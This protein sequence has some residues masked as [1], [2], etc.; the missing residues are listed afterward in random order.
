LVT[1]DLYAAESADLILYMEDGRI[2]EQGAHSELIELDGRYAAMVALM[3]AERARE[4]SPVT[5]AG[6]P[7]GPAV[8][9]ISH[10]TE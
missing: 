4:Q 1:H 9:E 7:S 6:G 8:R 5:S 3:T 2:Q 10:V